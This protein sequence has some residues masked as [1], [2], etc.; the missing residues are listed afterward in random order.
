[1]SELGFTRSTVIYELGDDNLW[2]VKAD[3][4][5]GIQNKDGSWDTRAISAMSIDKNKDNAV[6]TVAKS[7][8]AKLEMLEGNL[9][10]MSKEESEYE[11][12]SPIKNQ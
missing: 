2:T 4:V 10:N 9:F 1:M 8:T 6:M 5:A 7:L 3:S 11:L 12:P